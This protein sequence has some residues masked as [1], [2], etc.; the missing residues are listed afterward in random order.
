MN[1]ASGKQD[2]QPRRM[3]RRLEHDAPRALR[4]FLFPAAAEIHELQEAQESGLPGLELSRCDIGQ[5]QERMAD[6]PMIGKDHR[7]IGRAETEVEQRKL[8]FL[9]L[10]PADR[11]VVHG[12]LLGEDEAMRAQQPAK[13]Q[14]LRGCK[15]FERRGREKSF[16]DREQLVEM[17]RSGAP[18]TDD[19][20]RGRIEYRGPDAFCKNESLDD[21]E[22]G[23]DE[24][25][26]DAS[27]HKKYSPRRHRKAMPRQQWEPGGG[28]HSEPDSE[29][30]EW[31]GVVM[32]VGR[33]CSVHA[34][35]LVI[36]VARGH[37]PPQRSAR[38]WSWVVLSR[39]TVPDMRAISRLR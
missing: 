26:Y 7:L 16:I 39:T 36:C 21:A 17:R 6:L 3:G 14:A 4:T 10:I 1:C 5:V 37:M 29:G 32:S 12:P 23:A 13:R 33:A 30:V 25:R 28:D 15:T 34:S 18:V 38:Y 27:Q 35:P 9:R 11:H 2:V 19:E 22:A 8:I 20:D 31:I 24:R